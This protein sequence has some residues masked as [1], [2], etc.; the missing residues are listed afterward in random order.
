MKNALAD[1]KLSVLDL[2]SIPDGCHIREAF[3][4]TVTLAQTAD[5]LGY[6]RYWLAEHHNM[7]SIASAATSILIGHVAGHTKRIRVGS[8][9]IMLPNHAPLVIAEQFGTLE[10]LYPHR[11]DLGLGRAPGT[12]GITARALRRD[13]QA[14]MNFVEQIQELQYF[15][16][17]SNPDAPV[18]AIPGEGAD[19]PIWILGSST[20]S[21]YVAA[22]L[23]LPYAFASHF[24]PQ[25]LMQALAIYRREFKPSPFLKAPYTMACVNVM[26]AANDEYATIVSRSFK[27]LFLSMMK[28][29]R[30]KL[31]DPQ[32]LPPLTEHEEALVYNMTQYTFIGGPEKV[33]Q[34]LNDFVEKTQIQELMITSHI[35]HQET[36]I[37]SYK[38]VKSLQRI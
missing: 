1:I 20:D 37:N 35:Y 9:G 36:R 19:V 15:F 38:I 16:Y 5:A 12:D 8:G 22:A 13:Q 27:H 2:A 32:D 3:D 14:A 18:R 30:M 23:G 33:H 26:A 11:I 10:A 31:K 34:E 6:E 7:E 17:N 24:A 4:N 29:K 21:A 28:G 25:Q